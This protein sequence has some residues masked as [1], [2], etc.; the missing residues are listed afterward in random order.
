MR[1][2]KSIS[3]SF[4]ETQGEALQRRERREFELPASWFRIRIRY[5]GEFAPGACVEDLERG[6]RDGIQADPWQTDTCVG[7]WYNRRGIMYKTEDIRFPTRGLMLYAIAH[8]GSPR[9]KSVRGPVR[10]LIPNPASNAC[11]R[12]CDSDSRMSGRA[13]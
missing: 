10:R 7:E 13:G 6:V 3:C 11:R 9:L 1:F 8:R 4:V 2:Y 12:T 5:G